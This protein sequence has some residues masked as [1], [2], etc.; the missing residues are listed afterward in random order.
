MLKIDYTNITFPELPEGWEWREGNC[1]VSA[2]KDV[3]LAYSFVEW[4][5]L[6]PTKLTVYSESGVGTVSGT[7]IAPIEV[8]QAVLQAKYDV[9]Q[10]AE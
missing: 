10:V 7:G 8:I 9:A 4:L 2:Y 6:K 3:E 1:F 5:T